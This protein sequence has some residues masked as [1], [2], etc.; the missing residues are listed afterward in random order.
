MPVVP[1]WPK[2][3]RSSS[4]RS[5]DVFSRPDRP[6]VASLDRG[7][8]RPLCR[9]ARTAGHIEPRAVDTGG[10]SRRVLVRHVA[11]PAT[12]DWARP[13]PVPEP[14]CHRGAARLRRRDEGSRSS[15]SGRSNTASAC[16]SASRWRTSGGC[17]RGAPIRCA[18][19]ASPPSSTD[20]HWSPSSCRF[21]GRALRTRVRSCAGNP[22]SRRY[23][24]VTRTPPFEV[25]TR[26]VGPPPPMSAL[27]ER[28]ERCCAVI[29]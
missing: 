2:S 26:S 18:G 4:A 1:P 27:I 6:F 25:E 20:L 12:D 10:R 23:L 16:S 24:R 7:R 21:P 19:T 11:R 9:C 5:L 28:P 22:A 3:P 17:G 8:V 15:G 13:L 29:G 14:V